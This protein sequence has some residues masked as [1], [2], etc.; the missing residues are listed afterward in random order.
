M[1]TLRVITLFT[2]VLAFL[3]ASTAFAAPYD[4]PNG[5]THVV[6]LHDSSQTYELYIPPSAPATNR[7]ILYVF[8]SSGNGKSALLWLAPVAAANGWILAASNNFNNTLGGNT[9]VT[10]QSSLIQDT[11]ARWNV[12]PTRRFAGGF[13][14]G[15]RASL[16][17]AYRYPTKI[18]GT[19]CMGA[20]RPLTDDPIPVGNGLIVRMLIGTEDS[21]L[22]YD[23]PNTQIRLI[24]AGVRCEVSTYPG[25]HVWPPDSVVMAAARWL[26]DNAQI[27]PNA[28]VVP[29]SCTGQS[30]F[31]QAPPPLGPNWATATSNTY[32]G[33][34]AFEDFHGAQGL[35]S[36]VQWCGVSARYCSYY[37]EWLPC[38]PE[39]NNFI[40]SIHPDQGGFPG[41]A[42]CEQ[43]VTAQRVDGPGVYDGD[44]VIRHYTAQ[45]SSPVSLTSGW[46]R[47]QQ[48]TTTP[49]VSFWLG[50]PEGNGVSLL[51]AEDGDYI[52]D[53]DLTICLSG[54][55]LECALSASTTLCRPPAAVRFHGSVTGT[56]GE[57]I[58]WHWDFGDGTT[59]DGDAN[60]THTYTTDGNYTVTV[61]V[62]TP[63]RTVT[64]TLDSV[65]R[66]TE[67]L[68]AFSRAAACALCA[69]L[70]AAGCIIA[71]RRRSAK[72]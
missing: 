58:T 46:V 53:G 67:A 49:I 11:E 19:L 10:I 26:N 6:C 71:A 1:S 40:V 42:V 12:H 66:V 64:Q 56:M 5:Y 36:R 32:L 47:I 38:E 45:L 14:G 18:C 41:P 4:N 68:P 20:G 52:M 15:S 44:Y 13:S 29:Q 39:S 8:D 57:D 65:V 61:T 34:A 9:I 48:V 37:N 24:N 31:D 63:T 51:Y 7:P 17:L 33:S 25:G 69:A 70:L 23:I 30:L 62:T 43:T 35:I 60:P 21:N 22:T 54:D 72:T 2:L 16:L 59:L 27:D 55:P 50:S 28:G 3:S